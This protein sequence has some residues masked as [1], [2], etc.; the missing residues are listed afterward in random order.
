MLTRLQWNLLRYVCG[1]IP[2]GSDAE[3]ELITL[4]ERE[5]EEIAAAVSGL[6]A[7]GDSAWLL[8][9]RGLVDGGMDVALRYIDDPV[10]AAAAATLHRRL[11]EAGS[12]NGW[13]PPRAAATVPAADLLHGDPSTADDAI[14]RM[15]RGFGW[16][17]ANAAVDHK[18][19]IEY[20][21]ERLAAASKRE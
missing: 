10:I 8:Y 2:P 13:P 11:E 1:L 16:D 14:R 19:V 17:P 12:A 6:D 18:G 5:K 20:V 9:R 15:L 4:P 3:L 21:A 7:N